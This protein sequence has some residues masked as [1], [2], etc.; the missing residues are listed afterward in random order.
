MLDN[1]DHLNQLEALAS[2]HNWFGPGSRI[3][4]TTRDK[5]LLE[6]HEMD[7]LFEAK[8]IDHKKAIELFSWNAFKQNHPKE[9]YEKLSNS[10]VHYVNGLLMGLKVLGCFL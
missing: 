10:M 3:I 8:K 7:A 5:N 9:D 1:V 2:D 6:V 4:V